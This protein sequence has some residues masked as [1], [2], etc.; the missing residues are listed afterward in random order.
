MGLEMDDT[1]AVDIFFFFFSSFSFSLRI[2]FSFF[3]SAFICSFSS[4]ICFSRSLISRLRI[5]CCSV[6]ATSV[7]G[8]KCSSSDESFFSSRSTAES[9]LTRVGSSFDGFT[10]I[11]PFSILELSFF[12][13]FLAGFSSFVLEGSF[14]S[15]FE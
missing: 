15:S 5:S 12:S 11:F 4:L 7:F 8:G 10:D 1:D 13:L 9:F 14:L 3:F 2:F 6:S